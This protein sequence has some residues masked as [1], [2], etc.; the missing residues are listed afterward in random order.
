MR[1]AAR[2]PGLVAIW[3]P[4]GAARSCRCKG[5]FTLASVPSR[6]VSAA[7]LRGVITLSGELAELSAVSLTDA[8]RHLLDRIPAL[9]GDS[10][11]WWNVSAKNGSDLAVVASDV[12]GVDVVAVQR[13]Q[14]E[15]VAVHS[16]RDH[17][18]WEP[19]Y[20]PRTAETIR[21]EEVVSDRDW[22]MNPHIVEWGH[23]LGLDD[24]MVSVA[25]LRSAD[26]A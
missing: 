11:I 22:A 21:R 4:Q 3:L 13:W 9:I 19:A 5:A 14:E 25:P 23:A 6:K 16:Y 7:D 24:T 8:R 17:P 10:A 2:S 1:T 26:H 15:W 20:R 18:M 12:H